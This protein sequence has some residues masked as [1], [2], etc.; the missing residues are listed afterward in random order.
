[1]NKIHPSLLTVIS[2]GFLLPMIASF[3]MLSACTQIE[4][5]TP[6]ERAKPTS[7][8]A[9][10]EAT[11]MSDEKRKPL[12]ERF[13]TAAWAAFNTGKYEEAIAQADKC[14]GE[15]QGMA[16]RLQAQLEGEHVSIPIGSVFEEQKAQIYKNGLLNDVATCFFI[17]G[18]SAEALGHKDEARKAYEAAER[19]TRARTW[20]EANGWF[21]SPAKG[22]AERLESLK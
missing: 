10:Q 21:W 18:R 4:K 19:Y 7:F 6:S 22:A 17:R 2:H 14:I 11:E 8:N 3:A 12:N 9:K 1:M 13:T 20:D 16:N 15:F 5:K